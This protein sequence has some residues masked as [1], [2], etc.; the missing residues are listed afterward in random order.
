MVHGDDFV[1]TG[2]SE[3]LNWMDSMLKKAFEIKTDRIGPKENAK[4]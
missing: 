4:K 1:S 3:S 2:P